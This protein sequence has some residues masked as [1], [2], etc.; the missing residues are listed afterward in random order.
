MARRL[1]S[2]AVAAVVLLTPNTARAAE[3]VDYLVQEYHTALFSGHM[4]AHNRG[5]AGLKNLVLTAEVLDWRRANPTA[6]RQ[7][8]TTHLVLTRQKIDAAGISESSSRT[9]YGIWLKTLDAA[10]GIPWVSMATPMMKVLSEAT[11]GSSILDTARINDEVTTAHQNFLWMSKYNEVQ[12]LAWGDLVRTADGDADLAAAWD[13]V[14]GAQVSISS[15]ATVEQLLAD[16]L[17]STFVD[18]HTIMEKVDNQQ[19]FLQ[20]ARAQ[21]NDALARLA[22]QSEDIR[23]LLVQANLQFPVGPGPKPT[24]QRYTQELAY[25]ADRQVAIDAAGSAVYI[26]STLIGFT[27]AKGGR[28]V[29]TIGSAAVSIAT[30]INNYLPTVA[31]L[32]MAAL[33]SLSTVVLTGNILGAV[34]QLLP[35][36]TDSGP[37]ENQLILQEIGRLR[38]QV[39]GLRMEMHD[40]FDRVEAMLSFRYDDIMSVLVKMT[41]EIETMKYQ[42]E[43]VKAQL[44]VIDTKVDLLGASIRQSLGTVALAD[45]VADMKEYLNYTQRTG[46]DLTRPEFNGAEGH[47][48]TT[49]NWS[50][51]REPFVVTPAM[52]GS[53]QPVTASAALDEYGPYGSISY[54]S[55]LART[56]DPSFPAQSGIANVGVWALGAQALTTLSMQNPAMAKAPTPPPGTPPAGG[57]LA[58]TR[59]TG[60][61][62]LAAAARFSRPGTGGHTNALFTG[63]VDN[64]RAA[65][66]A[67]SDRL[68][69]IREQVTQNNFN[70]WYGPDQLP[71]TV[72]APAVTTMSRCDPSPYS[73]L[74]SSLAAPVNVATADLPNVY[75][76]AATMPAGFAPAYSVCYEAE[77]VNVREVTTPRYEQT[78]ADLRTTARLRAQFPGGQPVEVRSWTDTNP[79]GIVCSW[80]TRT[81]LPTG[82][83]LETADVV[84][85][86]WAVKHKAAFEAGAARSGDSAAAVEAARSKVNRQLWGKQKE[87]YQRVAADFADATSALAGH[88]RKV[89]EAVRLLQAYTRLGFAVAAETDA[90]LSGLLYGTNQLPSNYRY[91]GA[92][93][94]GE[95]PPTHI[96][97]AYDIAVGNYAPCTQSRPGDP[98]PD[99]VAAMDPRAGQP[100]I[101][102][103]ACSGADSPGSPNEYLGNCIHAVAKERATELAGLFEVHSQRL[104]AGTYTETLPQVSDLVA[105]LT[106]THRTVNAAS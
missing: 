95:L 8:I 68:R 40:R 25:A 100:P 103:P 2:A 41:D 29:A 7:D 18:V 27:D 84:R 57:H 93:I 48:T 65:V 39:D 82:Y 30:S 92:P 10:S 46:D 12:E 79:A 14:I 31:G 44:T 62:I 94:G 28:D 96:G 51:S 61:N 98:C 58:E 56:W 69:Q 72:R 70:P 59:Q 50:S 67:Q 49:A 35:L 60:Q 3:P 42:I 86:G 47:F 32:G 78:Y 23:E 97:R 75:Q 16:P 90:Q 4:R 104:A 17:L 34:M 38:E 106:L 64:Y 66:Q 83:C 53:G 99:A 13:G 102:S 88:N 6:S 77:L 101:F 80:T 55:Y 20:E 89:T 91:A 5:V 19:A 71:P 37:T 33:G 85:D 73:P 105:A 1:L 74:P 63:L 54:L 15:R 26:L 43:V 11:V 87:Y 36:F 22:E 81:P 76:L 21:V 9:Y 24:P 45:T 52:W